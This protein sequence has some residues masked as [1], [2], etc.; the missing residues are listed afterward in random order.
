MDFT[1]LATAGITASEAA[2]MF[3]VSRVTIY[4]WTQKNHPA[5]LKRA[6]AKRAEKILEAIQAAVN[7]GTLPLPQDTEKV[8]AKPGLHVRPAVFKTLKHYLSQP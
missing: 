1:L 2:F 3:K 4:K 7:D 8:A 6:N 5:A